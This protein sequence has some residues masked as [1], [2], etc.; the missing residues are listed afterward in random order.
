MINRQRAIIEQLRRMQVTLD[1]LPEVFD[2]LRRM[3]D[4]HTDDPVEADSDAELAKLIA[5]N[6]PDPYTLD[7]VWRQTDDGSEFDI[8][9]DTSGQWLD[10]AAKV[11][12]AV[13]G[14]CDWHGRAEAAEARIAELEKL[15]EPAFEVIN[16][17]IIPSP[18]CPPGP[19]MEI[20]V[21]MPLFN[22]ANAVARR[23]HAV[24]KETSHDR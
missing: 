21:P 12:E 19:P 13:L 14:P 16:E 3:E 22:R 5:D 2:I 11:R 7:I 18:P 9:E 15:L 6:L 20:S 4:K 10:L 8:T 1:L 23:I 24:L 17:I